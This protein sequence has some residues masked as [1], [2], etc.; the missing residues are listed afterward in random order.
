[1]SRRASSLAIAFFFLA[2]Y[3][4]AFG[5]ILL[6]IGLFVG[7]HIVLGSI[8]HLLAGVIGLVVASGLR[9]QARWAW[10]CGTIL[11][12]V[13][14]LLMFTGMVAGIEEPVAAMFFGLMGALF[15]AVFMELILAHREY[16]AGAR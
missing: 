2:C 11:S 4:L 1:M 15:V 16:R 7:P 13:I 10:W 12:L 8:A 5:T 14:I 9:H 3:G 6:P